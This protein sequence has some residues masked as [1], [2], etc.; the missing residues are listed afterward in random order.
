M[1][2]PGKHRALV[3]AEKALTD[4]IESLE[5]VD[6][7]SPCFS[8]FGVR[9]ERVKACKDALTEL[10][11]LRAQSRAAEVIGY[12]VHCP[13]EPDIGHWLLETKPATDTVCVYEPLVLLSSA[14]TAPEVGPKPAFIEPTADDWCYSFDEER[15]SGEFGT[16]EE[17]IAE[18]ASDRPD[19]THAY[20]GK[21]HLARELIGE[22]RIGWDIFE[23][24]GEIL[25]DEIGEVAE[26]FTMTG[27]QQKE[28]G[29]V[30]LDWIESGPGFRCW[31]VK[32]VE[33]VALTP[34]TDDAATHPTEGTQ[35]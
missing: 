9:A 23:R 6:R 34:E 24:I 16:R 10:T 15:F 22:D 25:G 14:P 7:V 33:R 30:V 35:S 13:G 28:L 19:H 32:E 27:D 4:A 3:L 2:T 18:A 29:K 8:G 5:Y 17:A 26:I 12:R 31:G 11:A 1:H 20:V 21:V